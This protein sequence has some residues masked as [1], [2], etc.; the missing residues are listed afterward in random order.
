MKN[1]LKCLKPSLLAGVFNCVL[2]L[3]NDLK[4]PVKVNIHLLYEPVIKFKS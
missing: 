1:K 4:G 3:G 2:T